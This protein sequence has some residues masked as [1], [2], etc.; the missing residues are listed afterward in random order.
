[1]NLTPRRWL[2]MLAALAALGGAALAS[3]GCLHTRGPSLALDAPAPKFKLR[4]NDGRD[5]EL[6]RL[7]ADGPA[8]V[9]FY[10]GFW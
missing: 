6:R 7:V 2:S 1:M 5:V 4:S 9:V 10:R 8:V 3:S